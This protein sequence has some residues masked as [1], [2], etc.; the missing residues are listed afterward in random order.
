[1]AE[2]PKVFRRDNENPQIFSSLGFSLG[3]WMRAETV[4]TVVS[5][6]TYPTGIDTDRQRIIAAEY[7]PET[8]LAGKLFAKEKA[9]SHLTGGLIQQ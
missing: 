2:Y 1:V 8:I 3:L 6:L 9:A 5:A 4:K 7:F